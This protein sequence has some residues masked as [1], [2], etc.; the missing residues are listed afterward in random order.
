MDSSRKKKNSGE[1]S[2]AEKKNSG[3]ENCS[4]SQFENHNYLGLHQISPRQVK[5]KPLRIA[6]VENTIIS[7]IQK[8]QDP[9]YCIF[10][11]TAETGKFI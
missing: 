1:N 11:S 4:L 3:A 10:R 8:F 7:R 5:P 9:V 6:T 2:G